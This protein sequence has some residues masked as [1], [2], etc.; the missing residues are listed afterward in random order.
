MKSKQKGEVVLLTAAAYM[1][2]GFLVIVSNG[3]SQNPVRKAEASV[4]TA[5][6]CHNYNNIGCK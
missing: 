3:F 1:I 2:A 6:V 4:Q 5:K